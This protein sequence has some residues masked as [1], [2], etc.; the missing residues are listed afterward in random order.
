[1]EMA[2]IFIVSDIRSSTLRKTLVKRHAEMRMNMSSRP[3]PVQ[4]P[5]LNS[6]YKSDIQPQ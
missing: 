4:P 3:M 1:M 6:C 5:Y 2:D